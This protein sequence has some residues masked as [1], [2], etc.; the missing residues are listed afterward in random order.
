[1]LWDVEVDRPGMLP[2]PAVTFGLGLYDVAVWNSS[3]DANG[4]GDVLIF[5]WRQ[6]QHFMARA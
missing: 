3:F 4:A 2:G 5:C 1:M 6:E